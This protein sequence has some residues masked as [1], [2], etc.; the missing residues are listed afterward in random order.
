[1][2]ET[3]NDVLGYAMAAYYGARA[4]ARIR[5]AVVP[6]VTVD[7]TSMYATVQTLMDLE[8]FLTCERIDARLVSGKTVMRWIRS[9]VIDSLFESRTWRK[10]AIICLVQPRPGDVLPIRARYGGPEASFGIGLNR[11]GKEP[12]EPLWYTLP[13]VVASWMLTGQVPDV[14]RAIRFAPVGRTY[15]RRDVRLRG[16][17]AIDPAAGR[18]FASVVERRAQ[19]P[20]DQR[21]A[22]LGRFLKVFASSTSYGIFA[23]MNR[24][25]RANGK[26]EQVHIFGLHAFD[27]RAVPE[28][29]E[30][31]VMSRGGA[32]AFCDTD[33][34]AIVATR[35]RRLLTIEGAGADGGAIEQ[36]IRALSWAEVRAIVT[37]FDR[38]SPYER[39]LVPHLLKVEDENSGPDG[40]QREIWCLSISAKRYFLFATETRGA[41]PIAISDGIDVDAEG[42]DE[43]EGTV[44][45]RSEHGLGHLLNPY[46]PDEVDTDWIA[47]AWQWILATEI[48]LDAPKP[49]WFDLPAV[50]RTSVSTPDGLT[51]FEGL[52]RGKPAERMVRPFNFLLVCFPDRVQG[53]PPGVDET[54]FRLVA[55]Y[56]RD[57]ARWV[58]GQWWEAHTGERF[59][60]TTYGMGGD[61]VVRVKTYGEVIEA[62]RVHEEA[63]SVG[64]DGQPCGKKTRGLLGRRSVAML[65]GGKHIGKESNRLEERMNEE[66]NAERDI[67]ERVRRAQMWVRVRPAANRASSI[68]QSGAQAARLPSS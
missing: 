9:L 64:P 7:F 66:L 35:R 2:S 26:T 40:R 52:N 50:S 65:N 48:G 30:L 68:R 63:K 13:D 19:L 57:T 20:E 14:I 53:L 34:M 12:T 3:W 56:E 55:P 31:E 15:G 23:E 54:R 37:R 60:I 43:G 62:Y 58:R 25:E 1:M 33:S 10:L 51:P 44:V 32:Y 18:F 39:R 59:R 24:R 21:K 47:E 8:R 41:V 17:V 36:R 11:W 28:T 4:E 38:L 61:G 22:G 6:V 67:L 16:E 42:S 46:D 49:S 45:K 5:L 27:T 29:P